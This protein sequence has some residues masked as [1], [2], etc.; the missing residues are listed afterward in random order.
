MFSNKNY[1][2]FKHPKQCSS[3]LTSPKIDLETFVNSQFY[4]Y[5]NVCSDFILTFDFL[6]INNWELFWYIP[7]SHHR[8]EFQLSLTIVLVG[9]WNF[10]LKWFSSALHRSFYEFF[11]LHIWSTI[12]FSISLFNPLKTSLFWLR[13]T[14]SIYFVSCLFL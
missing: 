7:F 12:K 9:M 14:T 5:E 1:V 2:I 3:P 6:P 10:S 4:V 11:L 13:N 8:N